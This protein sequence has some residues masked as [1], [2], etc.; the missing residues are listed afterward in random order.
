MAAA[1]TSSIPTQ[2]IIVISAIL[3][4]TLRSSYVHSEETRERRYG[5]QHE[6]LLKRLAGEGSRRHHADRQSLLICD[7]RSTA[8]FVAAVLVSILVLDADFHATAGSV[9][10]IITPVT[11]ISISAVPV[12]IS[13]L[14]ISFSIRVAVAACLMVPVHSPVTTHFPACVVHTIIVTHAHT[15]V[16]AHTVTFAAV[17]C[18]IATEFTVVGLRLV[19][20]GSLILWL[21]VRVGL[22]GDRLRCA[23]N[24]S[25][26]FVLSERGVEAR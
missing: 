12:S 19:A 21:G 11:P 7:G 16:G 17:H 3:P 4:N 18:P 5:V 15:I 24:R 22:G 26:S 20:A 6:W 14:S 1:I 10:I 2:T 13:T 23:S 9:F 25:F 8:W